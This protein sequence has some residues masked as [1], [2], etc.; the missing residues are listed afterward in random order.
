MQHVFVEAKTSERFPGQTNQCLN[1]KVGRH[2]SG[3]VFVK[4]ENC[5]CSNCKM[6]LFRPNLKRVGGQNS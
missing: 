6:Y 4:I 1:Y 5:I 2:L 3:I